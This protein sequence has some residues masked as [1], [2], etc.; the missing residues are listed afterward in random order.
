MIMTA[1][2]NCIAS[3]PVTSRGGELKYIGEQRTPKYS[4]AVRVENKKD[5]NGQWA[6]K[7]LDCELFGED[8]LYAPEL[9]G[10]EM[11]LCAGRLETRSWTG[12]DGETRTSTSLKCDFVMVAGGNAQKPDKPPEREQFSELDDDDGDLPF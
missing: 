5:E 12:R 2:G 7:F 10:R 9:H 3:G 1:K 4:F 8:A 6:S 11:V